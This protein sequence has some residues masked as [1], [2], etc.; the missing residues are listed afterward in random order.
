[1]SEIHTVVPPPSP[2]V[3][4]ALN[5]SVAFFNEHRNPNLVF[6]NY[7]FC[8]SLCS[9]IRT[10]AQVENNIPQAQT[11]QA[12]LAAIFYTLGKVI[13]HQNPEK[14]AVTLWKTYASKN[15][16]ESITHKEVSECIACLLYTSP[17]PR[18]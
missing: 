13:N 9:Q 14:D 10:I 16:I 15:E 18:D 11:E 17:S 4:H 12:Q 1:M 3:Q 5:H 2:I 8:N 6:H 7:Q